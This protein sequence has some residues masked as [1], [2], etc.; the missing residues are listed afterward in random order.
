ML[1]R[2]LAL[3]AACLLALPAAAQAPRN[4]PQNAL[5]GALL[6]GEAPEVAVNDKPARLS[7]GTRI[8]DA[9]NLTVV[10]A[11]L[12]GGRFLVNYTIDSL[13]QVKD[14][15]ILTPAEAANKPWPTTLQEQATWLFDPIAQV[16][17]KP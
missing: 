4:F 10:P 6:F 12:Y 17:A 7:P 15:W 9:G 5:R 1:F 13:G 11:S 16:W 14:V 3:A 2:A 8:R